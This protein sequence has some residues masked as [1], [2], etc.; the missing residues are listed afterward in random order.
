MPQMAQEIQLTVF[1]FIPMYF[2]FINPGGDGSEIIPVNFFKDREQ[3]FIDLKLGTHN[4]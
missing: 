3:L 2:D 1:I 4:K